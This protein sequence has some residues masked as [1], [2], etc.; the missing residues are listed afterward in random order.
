MQAIKAVNGTLVSKRP[1]AVDWAVAKKEYETAAAKNSS[2]GLSFSSLLPVVD[3]SR[4]TW[5]RSFFWY[6][7]CEFFVLMCSSL[8]EGIQDDDDDTTSEDEGDDG[9][10][11]EEQDVDESED[12]EDTEHAVKATWKLKD[13]ACQEA[14]QDMESNDEGSDNDEDE[15]DSFEEKDVDYSREKDLASKVL[16]KVMASSKRLDES[17][18]NK[19]DQIGEKKIAKPKVSVEGTKFSTKGATAVETT[20]AVKE[21]K[22]P[23]VRELARTNKTEEPV[24]E[25]SLEDSLKKTVF[26]RNLPSEAK[27]P[28]LRRQFSDFGEVKSFR[29]VLHPTTK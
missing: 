6:V 12:D 14:E 22:K 17:Q 3:Y 18:L 26:V 25:T 2:L 27:V 19:T 7:T 15:D 20:A 8:A 23:K 9:S 4:I 28:D 13:D 5:Y 16:E 11:D 1:I 24:A 10:E 29:L 21:V